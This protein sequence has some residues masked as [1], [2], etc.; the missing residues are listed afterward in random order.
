[1][2]SNRRATRAPAS[3]A[4]RPFTTAAPRS[5]ARARWLLRALYWA[6]IPACLYGLARGRG[7]R[8]YAWLTGLILAS[9]ALRAAFVCADERYQ[10]PVD[11]LTVVWLML[12]VRYSLARAPAPEPSQD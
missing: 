3:R 4:R 8:P 9:L 1:M 11:L 7:G 12:T 6:A 2:I 5:E 10:L